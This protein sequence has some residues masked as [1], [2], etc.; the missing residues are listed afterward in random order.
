MPLAP[1]ERDDAAE[2]FHLR[3]YRGIRHQS[4]RGRGPAAVAVHS[5]V[6]DDAP[7]AQWFVSKLYGDFALSQGNAVSEVAI[8]G[9]P[10]DAID[11]GGAGLILPLLAAGAKEVDGRWPVPPRPCSSRPTGSPPPLRCARRP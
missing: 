3:G 2:E 1:A 9:G 5:L 4:K 10:A 11:L 8:H 6:F 7:H